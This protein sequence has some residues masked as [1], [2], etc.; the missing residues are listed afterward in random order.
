MEGREKPGFSGGREGFKC[1][2]RF[3]F[4]GGDSAA[5]RSGA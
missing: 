2:L 3:K 1:K 4:K 5:L